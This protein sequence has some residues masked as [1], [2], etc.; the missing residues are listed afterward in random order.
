[1]IGV[2]RHARGSRV[3]TAARH[4]S[5]PRLLM[6]GDFAYVFRLQ[7]QALSAPCLFILVTMCRGASCYL[8]TCKNRSDIFSSVERKRVSTVCPA[9]FVTLRTP[10]ADSQ[11]NSFRAYLQAAER[12][13]R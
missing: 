11:R 13:A 4:S 12:T 8:A 10:V 6:S 1:M 7:L 2:G 3:I 5:E 9:R